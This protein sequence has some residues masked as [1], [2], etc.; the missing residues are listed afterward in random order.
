MLSRCRLRRRLYH[1]D[2][3]N[4]WNTMLRKWCVI[5]YV[6]CPVLWCS[7]LQIKLSLSKKEVG[8]IALIQA[9]HD[10]IPFMTLMKEIYFIFN[11][12]LLDPELFCK[13]FQYNQICVYVVEL[14]IFHKEQ[15][16]DLLIIT[17]YKDFYREKLFR[18]VTSIQDNERRTY[19]LSQ[20]NNHY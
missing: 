8:Y 12:L 4:L 5:T 3:D 10:V 9:M 18:Y 14:N 6:G 17:I 16:T 15:N 20:P 13:V 7:E 1:A 2:A 11:I 19:S